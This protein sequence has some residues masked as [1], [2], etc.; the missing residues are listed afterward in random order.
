MKPKRPILRYHGGKWKDSSWIISHFPKHD[1]Y[2]EA[3]GG[4]ASVL[5]NKER[6]RFE[7][8]NEL[9]EEI[10]NLFR[11]V[12]NDCEALA[13]LVELTPYS[14]SEFKLSYHKSDCPIERARRTLVRSF[15]G[16]GTCVTAKKKT[17]FRRFSRIR[18]ASPNIEWNNIPSNLLL[19]CE[20]LK[21]V[22]IEDCLPAVEC[23]EKQDSVS[24][25]HYLD[26]PYHHDTR[27]DNSMYLF[28]MTEN[29]HIE[30]AESVRKLK[31]MVIISG[32]A[33]PLYDNELFKDWVRVT[34]KSWADGAKERLEVI[35]MNE[36]SVL[37]RGKEVNQLSIF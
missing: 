28:E 20:R 6:S 29:Q 11:V 30:L 14:H 10:T 37:A 12:R 15:M 35:W 9:N 8:Y 5:M 13:E 26:P 2:V 1:K 4:S 24:T 17:G 22:L 31:G 27:H 33:H 19:I 21:G 32:Y 18:G 25:L 36:A 7:V 16:F 34:K 23:M 3:F